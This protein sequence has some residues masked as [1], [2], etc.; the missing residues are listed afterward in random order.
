MQKYILSVDNG[1]TNIKAV[2]FDVRGHQIVTEKIPNNA[3][4]IAGGRREF[5]EE[6][7]WKANSACIKNLI[8]KSEIRPEDICCIGVSGQ[9]KG[10]YMVDSDGKPIRN[11]ITSSDLRADSYCVKWENDGT[12]DKVFD[13]ILQHPIAGQTA[14]LLRWL[15]DEEPENYEKIKWVFSMKD[16]LVYK[17]TGKAVA[18][19]GC[20]SGTCLV[21]LLTKEYDRELLEAFGITEIEDKL[22]PLVWDTQICGYMTNEAAV[23]CGCRPE[24]PVAAGMFDVDAG[25][26]AMGITDEKSLFM[27]TGTCGVNGYVSYSPVTNGSVMFNSL[28]SLPDTYLI[29]DSSAASAGI[30]EWVKKILVKGKMDGAEYHEINEMV[31]SI[32][33]QNSKLIFLP[34]FHGFKHGGGE[35]SGISRGA[36]IGLCAEHTDRELFRAVYEGVAFVH[37]MHYE[38]L[39]NNREEPSTIK[40]AGG[41]ANSRVWMQLFADVLQMPVEVF[42]NNE[43]SAK[44]TAIAASVA[45]GIYSD[46]EEAI[47]KMVQP[48]NIIYPRKEYAQI[49]AEKYERFKRVLNLM[50]AVW[51]L[52]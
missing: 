13:K 14:P 25:V 30:L 41:A 11:A 15:K 10:L 16:Y 45:A 29:E 35:G 17:M 46:I 2:L 34:T 8:E 33:P 36:W 27:I 48:G 31:D 51:P 18:G 28:Y 21:N 52:F 39:V 32:E 38:H 44:G 42:E 47:E 12:S 24:T 19:K 26:L 5:D 7:L 37:K 23:E 1:G 9:G 40:V 22:P 4:N 43:M 20:Q 6:A 50:E 49:Y 3:L